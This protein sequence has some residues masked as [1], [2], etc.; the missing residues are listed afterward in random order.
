MADLTTDV[1]VE[2]PSHK[3]ELR[4]RRGE[5]APLTAVTVPG[6]NSSCE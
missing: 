5:N 3:N 2:N 1:T 6:E 4:W